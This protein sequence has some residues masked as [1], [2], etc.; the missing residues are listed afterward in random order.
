MWSGWRDREGLGQKPLNE[1]LNPVAHG[2]LN[3]TGKI[4][5]AVERGQQLNGLQPSIV[6]SD[7]ASVAHKYISQV[8]QGVTELFETAARLGGDPASNHGAPLISRGFGQE[9]EMTVLHS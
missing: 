8:L 7:H 9:R 2:G 1:G 4:D 5:L 6:F 3:A